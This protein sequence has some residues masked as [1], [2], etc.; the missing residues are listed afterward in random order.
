MPRP[1]HAGVTIDPPSYKIIINGLNSPVNES[2]RFFELSFNR[3]RACPGKTICRDTPYGFANRFGFGSF[4]LRSTSAYWPPVVLP[5]VPEVPD[6]P[7]ELPLV[8]P[9]LV[10]GEPLV[11]PEVPEVP[12]VPLAG[13]SVVVVFVLTFVFEEPDVPGVLVEPEVPVEPERV[14]TSVVVRFVFELTSVLVV[15][16]L[17]FALVRFSLTFVLDVLRFT[18]VEERFVS[19]IRVRLISRSLTR[20]VSRISPRS[21]STSTSVSLSQP[22]SAKPPI[23]STAERRMFREFRIGRTPYLGIEKRRCR[24]GTTPTSGRGCAQCKHRTIAELT[25]FWLAYSG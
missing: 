2:G 8:L 12:L 23:A 20:V 1:R 11:L 6:V 15:L 22:T 18:S 5:E 7:E 21:S 9:P 24:A 25:G 13:V 19:L 4:W 3:K 16:R 17:M 14:F 10:A